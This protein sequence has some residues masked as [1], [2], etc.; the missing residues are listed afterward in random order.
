[1]HDG[2]KNYHE[3]LDKAG[4]KNV[5]Y[6]SSG[7]AHEWLTWRRCLHE[8]APL[9]F[10]SAPATAQ[11]DSP[12]REAAAADN[13]TGTWKWTT[14]FGNNS[15]EVTLKL[16]LDGDKL[17]GTISGRNGE[18]AIDDSKYSNGDISFSVTRE[19]NGNK[20][21]S[22]YSGKQEGDTIKGKIEFERNG[23]TN[24]RDWEAKRAAGA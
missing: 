5:F 4:I 21:T 6:E 11:A 9:L 3:A 19:F 18:A 16:K 10:I 14:T 8:F 1:M 20:L 7:T 15:R 24:A 13:P 23:E 22:K 17:T 2:M 12:P